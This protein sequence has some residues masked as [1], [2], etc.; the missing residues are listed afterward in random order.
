MS[1]H[2]VQNWT[3]IWN[4]FWIRTQ[5]RGPFLDLQSSTTIQLR[6]NYVFD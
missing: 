6:V 2:F 1:I 4:V 3:N 5:A